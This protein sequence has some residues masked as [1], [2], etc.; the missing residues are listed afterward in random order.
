MLIT[1]SKVNSKRHV[2]SVIQ[3]K[4]GGCSIEAVRSVY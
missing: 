2:K 1:K 3:K 4:L